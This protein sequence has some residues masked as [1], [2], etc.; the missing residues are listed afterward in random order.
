MVS[1]RN[2]RRV[3]ND[4]VFLGLVGCGGCW[5]GVVLQPF[6][7]KCLRPFLASFHQ[8]PYSRAYSMLD[9]IRRL[10]FKYFW[11]FVLELEGFRITNF[12]EKMV[13]ATICPLK[14]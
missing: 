5:I 12:N 3:S 8:L 6:G 11:G 14:C 7:Q 4:C 9:Y 10:V 1:C 2:F 13:Y